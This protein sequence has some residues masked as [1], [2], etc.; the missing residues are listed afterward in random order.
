MKPLSYLK[1]DEYFQDIANK[2]IAIQDYCGTSV[3]ELAN[4][5]GSHEGLKSPL[6]ILFNIQSKLTGN[7]Q[8]TMNN[9]TISFTVAFAGVDPN[10]Y[11]AQKRAID[12]AEY[13][14]LQVIARINIDSKGKKVDW[15]Y[16]NFDPSTV[17]FNELEADT[18]EGL[19]GME[20]H[21][22]LKNSEPLLVDPDKWTDGADYCTA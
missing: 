5:I 13:I 18:V 3:N 4:K 1:I 11:Q 20:F 19:F 17:H 12:D 9:R 22:D 8:R 2:H 6:L 7:Q 14:G 16:N 15:L 21:F 10:D